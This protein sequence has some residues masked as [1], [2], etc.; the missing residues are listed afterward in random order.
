M[1]EMEVAFQES[2]EAAVSVRIMMLQLEPRDLLEVIE[3]R[4]SARSV[5]Y[6]IN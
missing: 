2:A 6:Y 1:T 5:P 3:P 4:V